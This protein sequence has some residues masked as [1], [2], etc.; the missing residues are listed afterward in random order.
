MLDSPLY[1]YLDQISTLTSNN[2]SRLTFL[3]L[4][5]NDYMMKD[6]ISISNLPNLASLR[7]C[8]DRRSPSNLDDRMI[9]KWTQRI[10]NSGATTSLQYLRSIEL[11]GYPGVTMR[12]VEY[13]SLLPA[14]TQIKLLSHQM[15]APYG[16]HCQGRTSSD[17][18]DQIRERVEHELRGEW[19]TL[20][21]RVDLSEMLD[22]DQVASITDYTRACHLVDG[23]RVL[24]RASSQPILFLNIGPA[25][26]TDSSWQDDGRAIVV[27]RNL[28][29]ADASSNDL[30]SNAGSDPHQSSQGFLGNKHPREE[31]CVHEA[32]KRMLKSGKRSNLDEVIHG[33]MF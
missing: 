24:D 5:Q 6:L 21:P 3:T 30:Q 31:Q 4:H 19:D 15:D 26:N 22:L 13:L 8:Q 12:S 23:V 28:L 14:L 1:S 33:F 32:K 29:D 20:H 9:W 16:W 18:N 11:S 10:V 25:W 7:L 17:L 27:W 2:E